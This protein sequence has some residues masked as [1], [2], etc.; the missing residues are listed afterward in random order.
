MKFFMCLATLVG[1]AATI[2]IQQEDGYGF[3]IKHDFYG[4][5]GGGQGSSGFGFIEGGQGG[6]QSGQGGQGIGGGFEGGFEGGYHFPSYKY[7]YGVKDIHTGD[8]KDAWEHRHG[9]QVEGEYSLKQPDGSK[10]IVKYHANDKEGFNAIVKNIGGGQ[11]GQGGSFG[12]QQGGFGQQGG[13][14]GFEEGFGGQGGFG[15]GAGI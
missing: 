2:P 14:G 7:S 4:G 11:G 1:I 6:G 13:Q 3:E 5:G 9:D 10:T 12:G 8:I 15:F